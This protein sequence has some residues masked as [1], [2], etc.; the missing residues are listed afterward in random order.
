[1]R[2]RSRAGDEPVKARRRKAVMPKRGGAFGVAAILLIALQVGGVN[3][4]SARAEENCLSAPNAQ[5]PQGSHWYY[6]IDHATQRHCWYIGNKGQ[7]AAADSTTANSKTAP[8][9]SLARQPHRVPT[10]QAELRDSLGQKSIPVGGMERP[11]AADVVTSPVQP[12]TAPADKVASPD[13]PTLDHAGPST[14]AADKVA[15]PDPPTSDHTGTLAKP[16]ASSSAEIAMR[17]SVEGNTTEEVTKIEEVQISAASRGGDTEN[18]FSAD[19]QPATKSTVAR[20][21]IPIGLFFALAIGLVLA[22]VFV[23]AAW[24]IVRG[25]RNSFRP[26][27]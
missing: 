24:T 22:G 27:A 2:R 14:A 9:H 16:D 12:S 7:Q 25:S 15:S 4:G 21:E 11:A 19:S 13:P 17:G 8:D 6:R 26:R 10:D 1:M 5:A 23:E 18:D 3:P 20:R